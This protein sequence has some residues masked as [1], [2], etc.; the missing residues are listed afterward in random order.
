MTFDPAFLHFLLRKNFHAYNS[1]INS[2]LADNYD[3]PFPRMN[4]GSIYGLLTHIENA[5]LVEL[6]NELVTP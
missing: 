4:I 2:I 5:I 3:I 6:Q 1:T